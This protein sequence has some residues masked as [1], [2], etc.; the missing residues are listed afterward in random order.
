QTFRDKYFA[1][2]GDMTNAQSFWG[3][4]ANCPGTSA[5]GNTDGKTCNGDGDGLI[6]PGAAASNESFRFWQH[7]ANAGL[8]E[9]SYNGV[10]GSGAGIYVSVKANAPSSKLSNSLWSVANWGTTSGDLT[11]F[12]GAH[13]NSFQLGAAVTNGDNYYP[14]LKPEEAWNIDTKIDDG[15]PA[16]GKVVARAAVGGF[17]SC[18]TAADSTGISS[19]YNLSYSQPFCTMFFQQLF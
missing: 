1:L 18:T 14:V 3:S 16:T 17:S 6:T 19:S 9:G 4:S 7:L 8:I 12:D 13:G 15:K 2:P 10:T 11:L 5:Q